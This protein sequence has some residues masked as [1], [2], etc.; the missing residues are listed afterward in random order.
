MK[1]NDVK[2][3][4]NILG[5]KA[6]L[7]EPLMKR[8][9]PKK[10][11]LQWNYPKKLTITRDLWSKHQMDEQ[12]FLAKTGLQT[13]GEPTT[14]TI[15]LQTYGG[16][17]PTPRASPIP[18][19]LRPKPDKVT[20]S[21]IESAPIL[22]ALEKTS[23]PEPAVKITTKSPKN[24][25]EAMAQIKSQTIKQLQQRVIDA[26]RPELIGY[27]TRNWDNPLL[28]EQALSPSG[29][30]LQKRRFQESEAQKE[31]L[32]RVATEKLERQL[33]WEQSIPG[34]EYQYK[35]MLLGQEQARQNLLAQEL[36]LQ[37]TQ[38]QV[39]SAQRAAQEQAGLRRF[40]ESSVGRFLSG[41]WTRQASR[42]VTNIGTQLGGSIV[43]PFTEA[44]ASE[45]L[46][47][48]LRNRAAYLDVLKRRY[49][50]RRPPISINSV[51]DVLTYGTPTE[52]KKIAELQRAVERAQS[53]IASSGFMSGV[54]GQ[55]IIGSTRRPRN[56]LPLTQ[57]GYKGREYGSWTPEAFARLG[58]TQSI[59]AM[60]P[61][62]KWGTLLGR[63]AQSTN[64]IAELLGKAPDPGITPKQRVERFSEAQV[65]TTGTAGFFPNIS[66]DRI[67]SFL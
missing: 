3:L 25:K 17:T 7:D 62:T 48:A 24:E 43:G 49:Q 45:K 54:S 52:I 22:E 37:A 11:D 55:A 50:L 8:Y 19:Y 66:I 64:R 65:R 16:P 30:A 21:P 34:Q 31:L 9:S 59:T 2:V 26:G 38:A 23:T 33:A 4:R 12:E 42:A 58:V 13:Y 14:P 39:A 57:V 1:L 56:I 6:D 41:P 18:E 10:L 36:G 61:Q 32:N 28:I 63:G 29:W 53:G 15:G 35:G 27:V 44:G 20:L 67:K 47:A 60:T 46:T 40:E 5:D 51:Q